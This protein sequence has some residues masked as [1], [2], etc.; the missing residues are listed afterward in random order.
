VNLARRFI[1]WL[2]R[3]LIVGPFE[4][5]RRPAYEVDQ[6]LEQRIRQARAR[7]PEDSVKRLILENPDT[8]VK[9]VDYDDLP[10]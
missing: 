5:L 3:P 1:R 9:P 10:A 8:W 2:K 6:K 7:L 4:P